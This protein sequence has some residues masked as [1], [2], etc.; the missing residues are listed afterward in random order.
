MIV[1]LTN[2]CNLRCKMCGI[3]REEGRLEISIDRYE[4]LLR[5][6]AARKLK[7]IALTGGEPFLLWNLYDY[8]E[9]ARRFL[10][11]AH[12]N[13]STNGQC[14]ERT[15]EFLRRADA[16]ATSVTISYDGVVSHDRIRG[17]E[18][19]AETVLNTARCIRVRHPRV[20][21]SLKLTITS[22]NHSELLDTALKCKQMGIPLRIKTL[23][24][25]KC[26]QSRSPSEVEDPDYSDEVIDS[27]SQQAQKILKMGIETNRQYVMKLISKCKG[28]KLP[29]GCSPRDLFVGVDGKLFL[30]RKREPIGN[31]LREPLDVIWNSPQKV[32][33]VKEMKKCEGDP[34]GLL[35]THR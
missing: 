11:R 1:E 18:G 19:S 26:H 8:Y 32:E 17:V 16:R 31:I 23:E 20:G 21:L 22:D 14:T 2:A 6:K 34:V 5:Q 13:I 24:K 7:L 3:W 27:I 33:R 10:P 4:E 9:S 28:A 30:C 12:V 29:C 25:L 15:L 35:F